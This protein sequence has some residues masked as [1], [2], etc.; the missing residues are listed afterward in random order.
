MP[1]RK[2]IADALGKL[3]GVMWAAVLERTGE[4]IV[5]SLGGPEPPV[6][7]AEIVA[8]FGGAESLGGAGAGALRSVVVTGRATVQVLAPAAGDRILYARLDR[9]RTNVATALREVESL[10]DPRR[11]PGRTDSAG[12]AP[13]TASVPRGP[14]APVALPTPREARPPGVPGPASTGP[15]PP[16]EKTVPPPEE[17]APPP[18]KAL[19]STD[20][21]V[22]PVLPLRPVT[23][24]SEFFAAAHRARPPLPERPVPAGP[25]VPVEVPAPRSDAGAGTRSA[26]RAS[27]PSAS[28]APASPPPAPPPAARPAGREPVDGTAERGAAEPGVE[29]AA[30]VLPRRTGR[31]AIPPPRPPTGDPDDRRW[32]TDLPTLRRLADGLRR[33]LR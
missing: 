4:R 5:T 23:P 26:A 7:V 9:R 21:P 17:T 14:A 1:A 27:P 8:A 32:A 12:A 19:S 24:V 31:T 10:G 18:E 22:R 29:T 11:G 13:R 3:P 2:T 20:E 16:P 6:P 28:P 33:R 15:V 25:R 30:G